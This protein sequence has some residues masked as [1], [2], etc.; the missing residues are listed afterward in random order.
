MTHQV[1]FKVTGNDRKE[2]TDAAED[3]LRHFLLPGDK[4]PD[5][6]LYATPFVT[7]PEGKVRSWTGEVTASW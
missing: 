2:L 5:Y 1:N 4:M 3:V 6:E 7:N